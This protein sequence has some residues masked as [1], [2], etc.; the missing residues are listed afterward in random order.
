MAAGRRVQLLD[1]RNEASYVQMM[2]PGIQHPPRSEGRRVDQ[3][4]QV[5]GN[6]GQNLRPYNAQLN[7]VNA[8]E[9]E[10]LRK[11][12]ATFQDT[13]ANTLRR[14]QGQGH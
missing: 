10:E 3:G 9:Q 2:N 8:R 1:V 11:K 6:Q 5:H 12:N 13:Y 7:Q 14:N 4:Y